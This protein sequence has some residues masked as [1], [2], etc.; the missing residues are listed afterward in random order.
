MVET[1]AVL[2]FLSS[3]ESDFEP[4]VS[5]RRVCVGSLHAGRFIWFIHQYTFYFSDV[6]V[7]TRV[8]FSWVNTALAIALPMVSFTFP[9]SLTPA[10]PKYLYQKSVRFR[11]SSMS[12]IEGNTV[13]KNLFVNLIFQKKKFNW[14][15][16]DFW[17]KL[18]K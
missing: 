2:H 15:F 1:R 14:L 11:Y 10:P 17:M 5:M 9:R 12:E 6:Q 13:T 3:F 18:F 4:A 8:G 16:I 7:T